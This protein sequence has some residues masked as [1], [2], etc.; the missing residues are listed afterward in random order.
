MKKLLIICLVLLLL[1][2]CSNKP[3]EPSEASPTL[4]PP[5]GLYEPGNT[6]EQQS[7]G[8]VRAYP[9]EGD[10]YVGVASMGN[11][12]LLIGY[13]GK[14]TVLSGD[15]GEPVATLQVDR[16]LSST[17]PDL[18]ATEMGVAYY[19]ENA[20]QVVVLNPQLQETTR[21]TL[22]EETLGKP[23]VSLNS[24][25]IYYCVGQEI[26]EMNM[27]TRITRMVKSMVCKEQQLTGLHFND[28]VLACR[29]TDEDDISN[30]IYIS[31]RTGE[32]LSD[33]RGLFWLETYGE[34]YFAQ[35][36]DGVV[37]Q[38]IVAKREEEPK[39]LRV[40]GIGLFL[41]GALAQDGVV[42]CTENDGGQQLVFYNIHSGKRTSMV[43][44]S[45]VQS[46]IDLFA[47]T[48]YM[49]ILATEYKSGR[50][51]LYRW[52]VAKTPVLDETVYTEKLDTA[53]KP[54]AEGIAQCKS[55]IENINNTYDI[56]VELWEEGCQTGNYTMSVEHQAQAIAGMLDGVEAALKLFPDDFL[57]TIVKT[58]Q[59]RVQL[60]RSVGTNADS[61]QYWHEGDCYVAITSGADAEFALLQGIGCGIDTHVLGNSRY[62]DDWAILNPKGFSY[63][64]DYVLNELRQDLQYLDGEN[65]AFV[66]KLSMSYI[67][68]D[69]SRVFAAAMM[70]GNKHLFEL[71]IMQE[72]LMLLCKGIREAYKLE[73]SVDTYPWE[74]YLE[75]PIA[76][77]K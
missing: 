11:K 20:H 44:L 30:V 32:T 75:T 43:N 37:L 4:P 61:A 25:V 36:L 35:R 6:V 15:V 54:D 71:E 40:E 27:K 60:V 46:P 65:R 18:C 77:K 33:D 55:R 69:R 52:D 21:Y 68:E 28:T 49:W 76:P 53:Q 29:V 72:K 59:I 7:G 57:G 51:V 39:N 10:D 42:S 13:E 62:Y 58:G 26:W 14:M 5:T 70:E 9:L 12:M 73:K 34:N 24:G 16:Y 41:V 31:T 19:Q 63:D 56:Y 47:D 17:D 66:D 67:H 3:T 38:Q 48:R 50:T 23:A 45:G 64:N 74:Q 8:A 2:G 22:P 1:T